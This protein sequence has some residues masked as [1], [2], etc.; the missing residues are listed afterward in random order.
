M[1]IQTTT[2]RRVHIEGGAWEID[3]DWEGM[4]VVSLKFS[5]DGMEPLAIGGP[6]LARAIARAILA[7]ADDI[8]TNQKGEKNV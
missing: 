6:E 3:S 7:A 1:K 4:D 2:L 8:E 5:E